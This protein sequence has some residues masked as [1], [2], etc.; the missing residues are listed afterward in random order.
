[1]RLAN[2]PAAAADSAATA[3]DGTGA[4]EPS[5]A[6]K[7]AVAAVVAAAKASIQASLAAETST[8]GVKSGDSKAAA[9]GVEDAKVAKLVRQTKE[10]GFSVATA[11]VALLRF[12][13]NHLT[14]LPH[15][16][17]SRLVVTHDA[18]ALLVR[19]QEQAPWMRSVIKEPTAGEIARAAMDRKRTLLLRTAHD[20]SRNEIPHWIEVE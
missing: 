14:R 7:A 9:G 18:A 6:E 1:M 4:G 10:V 8:S 11:C 12:F 17:V 3:K 19:V 15:S 16:S 2:K 13:T 5:E 20:T